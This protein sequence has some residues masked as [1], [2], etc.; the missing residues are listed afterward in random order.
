[1]LWGIV[2]P[3]ALGVAFA[4]KNRREIEPFATMPYL[5]LGGALLGLSLLIPPLG[6][7][8]YRSI[9]RFFAVIGFIVSNIAL[10]ITFYL[11]VTPLGWILKATGK[12]SMDNKFKRE[13]PPEW[14]SHKTKDDLRRYYRL[15]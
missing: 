9:L 3:L 10:T 12:D 6:E 11:A 14:R 2:L 7:H 13:S 4:F 8:V 1:M 15:F 5:L